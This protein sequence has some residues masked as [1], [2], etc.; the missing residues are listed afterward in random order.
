VRTIND[1]TILPNTGI[2]LLSTWQ[3]N[4]TGPPN[5]LWTPPT[6]LSDPAVSGP[7]ASIK[8]DI[9]YIVTAT[10]IE[11]CAAMDTVNLKVFKGSGIFVPTGF[12]PN[13]DGKND[14]L[15][16]IYFDITKIHYFRVYN[17]WGQLVFSS[18][19]P[20]EG[21]DGKLRGIQQPAGSYVWMLKAEDLAGEIYELKG[22]STIIR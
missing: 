5:F 17:R 15:R 2:R 18:T 4:S 7:M 3:T 11:G 13:N 16:P 19:K 12:T 10:T 8:D 20:G 14:V 9:T 21:W 6:D 1:T 22:I